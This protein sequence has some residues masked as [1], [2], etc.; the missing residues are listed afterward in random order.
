M[1]KCFQKPQRFN[2]PSF[3]VRHRTVF[4]NHCARYISMIPEQDCA[5][6]LADTLL[7]MC[8]N[9]GA[10]PEKTLSEF[11][12]PLKQIEYGVY[13]NLIMIY[14]KPYYIY[15]GDYRFQGESV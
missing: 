12:V 15:L 9:Q 14:P 3:V 10:V 8:Q 4:G 1:N 7:N 11:I 13:G 6:T 2:L 5:D